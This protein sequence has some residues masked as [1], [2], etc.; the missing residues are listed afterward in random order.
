MLLQNSC[1]PPGAALATVADFVN[2]MNRIIDDQCKGKR[3]TKD[4]KVRAF[5]AL[6]RFLAQIRDVTEAARKEWE[7]EKT[8]EA[9]ER[10]ARKAL[11]EKENGK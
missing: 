5:D 11:E 3:A 9:G 7:E 6:T 4:A 8:F 1:N 10:A 2:E